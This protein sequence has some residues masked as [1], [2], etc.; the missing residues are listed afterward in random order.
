MGLEATAGQSSSTVVE[1]YDPQKLQVRTDV[2]LEDV[3]MVAP[4]QPVEIT[5]ASS[6]QTIHGRVLQVTSSANIQKN[7][8]EVKVELLDPPMTVGPEML[9][10]ATFLSPQNDGSRETQSP[11]ERMFVPASLVQSQMSQPFVWIADEHSTA[12]SRPVEIGG[13]SNDDLVEI[14][15]GLK[16]TDKLITSGLEG[17]RNG[18]RIKLSG[19]DQKLG[20]K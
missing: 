1:M 8:L 4:G 13:K 18:S 7:T 12:Q 11:A 5:T 6:S 16:V 9:A 17:L 3:P 14:K 15:S 10:T 20:L 2:R 19:D